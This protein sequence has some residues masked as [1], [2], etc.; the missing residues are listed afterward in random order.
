MT[1]GSEIELQDEECLLESRHAKFLDSLKGPRKK[2]N[3]V[4]I[5]PFAFC[6]DNTFSLQS[7][8]E[9]VQMYKVVCT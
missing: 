7:L 9:L 8:A 1:P 6:I 3:Q 2:A 4:P 5:P